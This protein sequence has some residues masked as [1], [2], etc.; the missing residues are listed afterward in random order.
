MDE[1]R[2]NIGK[3]VQ[4]KMLANLAAAAGEIKANVN[5]QSDFSGDVGDAL[6]AYI[7]AGILESDGRIGGGSAPG[8][9]P[10]SP[11]PAGSEWVN[12]DK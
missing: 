4:E 8:G 9:N 2:N 12:R 5:L 7:P 6:K 10:N 11:G 3:A 1:A